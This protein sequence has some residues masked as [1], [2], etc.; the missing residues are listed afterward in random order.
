[1]NDTSTSIP[2]VSDGGSVVPLETVFVSID[3][4]SDIALVAYDGESGIRWDEVSREAGE[5]LAR[6]GARAQVHLGSGA[7]GD[8]SSTVHVARRCA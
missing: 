2:T 7:Q 8:I 1:M 4:D 6:L 5:L 3:L